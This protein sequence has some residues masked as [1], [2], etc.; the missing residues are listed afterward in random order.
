MKKSFIIKILASVP[1]IGI[2]WAA[3]HDISAGEPNVYMEYSV[4]IASGLLAIYLLVNRY[5]KLKQ[6]RI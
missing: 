6:N 4:V 2:N 1:M 5:L 3:L